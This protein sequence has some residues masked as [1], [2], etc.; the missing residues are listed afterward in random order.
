[1]F[2]SGRGDDQARGGEYEVAKKPEAP[3]NWA[4]ARAQIDRG[5]TGDKIAADDPAAAPLGTDAEAG[6]AST[7]AEQ[8]ARSLQLERHGENARAA[9]QAPLTAGRRQLVPWLVVIVALAIAVV[10]ALVVAG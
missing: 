3:A 6:G 1:L 2:T 4:Q 5:A 9:A 7:P 8:I 10:I